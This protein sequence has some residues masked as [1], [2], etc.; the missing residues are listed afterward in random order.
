MIFYI[1]EIRNNINNKTY[2][3]QHK[4]ETLE[5]NY[6]GSGVIIKKAINKYGLENFTKTILE[7]CAEDTVNDRE[8]Y[9]I[10]KEKS[11]GKAEYNIAEGGYGCGN[12]FKYKTKEELK[13]IYKKMSKTRKGRPSG[14]TGKRWNKNT[15]CLIQGEHDAKF[16]PCKSSKRLQCIETGQIFDSIRE[17]CDVLKIRHESV[18]AYLKGERTHP[19]GGYTFNEIID[20]IPYVVIMET[21]EEFE[22]IIDCAKKL[23]ADK[24]SVIN[25]LNGKNKTCH[26]YHICY[27]ENYNK[28]NNPYLG[29]EP[30]KEKANHIGSRRKCAK[31][32]KAI[33]L[34]TKEEI[35][36]R[37]IGDCARELN[38]L[39]PN[40]SNICNKRNGRKVS[41]GY[42]FE[43][44]D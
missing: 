8:V 10:A 32:V 18:S 36:F 12:P 27:F 35:I 22:T 3:G 9:W 33:N 19:I 7:E 42:T 1:Y 30:K 2:I 6:F 11:K 37:C 43:F 39:R 21:E 29:K 40:I 26:G 31:K 15:N 24:N 28:N 44:V 4:S 13:T 20:K 14:I 5:D 16:Q 38:V 17:C 25:V 23:E 41:Q 34:N